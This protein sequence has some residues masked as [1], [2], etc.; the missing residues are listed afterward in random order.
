[1]LSSYAMAIRDGKQISIKAE[2]L[3]PGDIVFLQSGDKVPADLRL[4]RVKGLQVQESALTGESIAVE[5][6]IEQVAK[7][8]SIG[9]RRCMAFSSTLVTQGQGSGVVVK[10]GANTEIGR[11]KYTGIRSRATNNPTYSTNDPIWSLVY[12]GYIN[13]CRNYFYNWIFYSRL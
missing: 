13:H 11:N 2:L 12:S 9:D 1:M 6:I 4:F 7:E 10:T 5:K 3:V 8:S